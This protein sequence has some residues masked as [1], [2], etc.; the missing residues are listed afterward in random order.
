M[1]ELSGRRL[2]FIAALPTPFVFP[3]AVPE[4]DQLTAFLT[5]EKELAT[6]YCENNKAREEKDHHSDDYV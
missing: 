4:R 3:G 1:N 6:P 2:I 5:P